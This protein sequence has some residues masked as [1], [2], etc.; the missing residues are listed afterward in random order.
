MKSKSDT[1]A[2]DQN[3]FAFDNI[4][5]QGLTFYFWHVNLECN[6]LMFVMSFKNL[7]PCNVHNWESNNTSLLLFLLLQRGIRKLGTWD[8]IC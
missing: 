5:F 2:N 4:E 7:F 3:N 1:K 6:I 8:V